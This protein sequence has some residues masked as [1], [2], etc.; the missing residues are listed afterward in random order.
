MLKIQFCFLL[1]IC[2]SLSTAVY[3]QISPAG[4]T[5][6]RIPEP[7]IDEKKFSRREIDLNG[8]NFIRLN[9][10]G[11]ISE[12]LSDELFFQ[13]LYFDGA[14][15]NAEDD[16]LPSY[17][18]VKDLKEEPET[19]EII[20]SHEVYEELSPEETAVVNSNSNEKP[21][22][23]SAVIDKKIDIRSVISFHQKK[24]HLTVSFVPIRK[25]ENTGKY[26]KLISFHISTAI[27][28]I[29]KK[30]PSPGREYASASVLSTGE[31]YK[32]GVTKDGVYSLSYSFLQSM[33]MDMASVNPQNIRIY[34]NGGGMLPS[35]NWQYRPDDLTE[36]AI[37]VSGEADGKF[38]A[39]DLIFFY[40]QGPHRWI[41]NGNL[42]KHQQNLYADTNYYFITADLGA[43]KRIISK[44]ALSDFNSTVTSFNDY[45][46]YERDLINPVRSGREWLGET[47]SIVTDYNF[48]FSFPDISNEAPVTLKTAVAGRTTSGQNIFTVKAN[49]QTVGTISVNS[50]SGNYTDNFAR[51]AE[52]QGS[53]APSGAN[54]SINISMNKGN[55]GSQGWLDFIEINARRNLA[56][57]GGQILF[58]DVNSVGIGNARFRLSNADAN[59]LV[60]DITNPLE[61]KNQPGSLAGNIFEFIS[62]TDS[63]GEF[64]AFDKTA[65]LFSPVFKEKIPAQNLHAAAAADM[66]IVTN[67]L[68]KKESEELA[69]FH[70]SQDG[71]SVIVATTDEIF[72]E[73]SSGRQD[74]TAIKD[75]LKMFY[76]RAGTNQALMPKYLLLFGDGSYDFKNRISGNTNF[77]PAYQSSESLSPTA[78]YVSDDYYGLLDDNESES[79]TDL[80]DL[81]VGRLVVKNTTEAQNAVKKIKHY[82]DKET[83]GPWRNYNTF[84]G[85]DEDGNIH[86]SQANSI[87]GIVENNYKKYNVDKILFDAYKQQVNAGGQRYPDV[88]AA[89]DRRM[90][91][92]SLMMTYIGHGGELG[93]AHER[94]LE[95]SQINKWTN[96]NNMPL[97]I[98]ATCEFSRF[99]DPQRTAAGEFVFLNPNGGGIALLS[100]TRLVYSSPNYELVQAFTDTAFEEINSVMPRLGDILKATK[101]KGPKNINSRNFTLLGDPALR[102]AYPRYNVVTTQTPDTMK[103][104]SKVT[105]KGYVADGS[106]QK[107]TGFDGV[108]YPLVFDK[109]ANINTLNNDNVY[110]NEEPLIYKF[111][112]QKNILFKGKASVKSGEFEYSFV[113]PKDISYTYGNGRISHY[114]QDGET[115]ASGYYS[116]FII[117]GSDSTAAADNSGPQ[118]QLYLNDDKFVFGGITDENPKLFARLFDENGINTAGN[119]IGHDIVAVL[120][121]NTSQALILNDY[122]ESEINSYQ[123]GTIRYPLKDLQEGKHTLRLKAFDVYNNSGEAGTEFIVA[124]SAELALEHVLNYPNPFTTSTAFYFEHNQPGQNLDIS[125]QIFTVAGKLV[126]SIDSYVYAD[127]FRAG[128]IYW[129]G[130]DDFGDKIGKGV[131]V[132]K[133]KVIAP[134]G[135][136]VNKYEKLVVLN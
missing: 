62:S 42:F 133:L 28:G 57:S 119:G 107:M 15:I 99:D 126:K 65:P 55:S 50:V 19:A 135:Q 54:I 100:T 70:R 78:S 94:V 13:Y 80:V 79:T 16:F 73:F 90:D 84:I 134:T 6:S 51:I 26:E 46:F 48:I 136:T 115:D 85:D 114:S 25:N 130:M 66:I 61:A 122:Y 27:S 47:F 93:W 76:D 81:G 109:A 64:I 72:N 92:G 36:N 86:M 129:D 5:S 1:V 104:L 45:Q 9:W 83:M 10:R 121:E 88:N 59:M 123:R 110:V 87:A 103:A 108:V 97:L 124:K 18:F 89:I 125:I 120:D 12:R 96:F 14:S 31:W 7:G 67:P 116:S 102:L 82:Y 52:G 41:L 71:F 17:Y 33:G 69:E 32:I 111:Q 112:S 77:V 37:Y 98:T 3:S 56:L 68:F 63:L 60:W 106:G 38:D 23:H 131:Y 75:Y 58:R 39:G 11:I 22:L 29:K 53:F 21:G 101:I 113:V 2:L 91:L 8:N 20:I 105:V 4:N 24:P 44:T 49:G 34:G 127:T 35:A 30:S 74:V 40:G 128:P 132:Y 118:I 117:G 95:V 43:G